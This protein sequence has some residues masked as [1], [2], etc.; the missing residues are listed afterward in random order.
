[1]SGEKTKEKAVRRTAG[2]KLWVTPDGKPGMEKA[3]S[4]P[5]PRPMTTVHSRA[6]MRQENEDGSGKYFAGRKVAFEDAH[7]RW[8]LLYETKSLK[9]MNSGEKYMSIWRK[10]LLSEDDSDS[11]ELF[12]DGA[13]PSPAEDMKSASHILEMSVPVHSH[14][15]MVLESMCY[16]V[17]RNIKR[18]RFIIVPPKHD[19][20]LF[21]TFSVAAEEKLLPLLRQCSDSSRKTH[22]FRVCC[23]KIAA[24]KIAMIFIVYPKTMTLN[25]PDIIDKK[26]YRALVELENVLLFK[27]VEKTY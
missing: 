12:Q 18:G 22:D 9:L 20:K 27:Q 8:L 11:E 24:P 26:T 21:D 17:P 19:K 6:L 5:S 14:G 23:R 13:K 2:W 3:K 10:R 7:E 4:S 1:M 25:M 15:R 16:T